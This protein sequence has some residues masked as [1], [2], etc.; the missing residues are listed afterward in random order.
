MNVYPAEKY[1]IAGHR[2]KVYVLHAGNK[3]DC[4]FAVYQHGKQECWW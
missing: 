2:L 4:W 3:I 1:S